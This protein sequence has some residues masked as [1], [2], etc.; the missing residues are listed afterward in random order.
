MVFNIISSIKLLF[1]GIRMYSVRFQLKPT[2]ALVVHCVLTDLF[3]VYVGS[4]MADKSCQSKTKPP[5]RRQLRPE[6]SQIV[7]KELAKV[8]FVITTYPELQPFLEM[9]VLLLE[10]V[11]ELNNCNTS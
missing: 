11:Y 9:A 5:G 6:P 8:E 2:E 4:V 1:V 7:G 3:Y 10:G